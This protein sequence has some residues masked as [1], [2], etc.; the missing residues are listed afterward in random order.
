MK[1]VSKQ[2]PEFNRFAKELFSRIYGMNTIKAQDTP[3]WYQW[4][5]DLH[6]CIDE[7][8]EIKT[9]HNKAA[10]DPIKAALSTVE[11]LKSIVPKLPEAK[12]DN[13]EE[14]DK[15]LEALEGLAEEMETHAGQSVDP[16]KIERAHDRLEA[17][18]EAAQEKG[19][20]VQIPH[21]EMRAAI[22]GTIE[23]L[24]EN[25]EKF[26]MLVEM[27]GTL[28]ERLK[29]DSTKEYLQA[30]KRAQYDKELMK[31][32]DLCGNLENS[33]AREKQN[34]ETYSRQESSDIVLGDDIS[35]ALLVE[36][37]DDDLFDLKFINGELLM[38][39]VKTKEPKEK[40]DVVVCVDFSGSMSCEN[41]DTIA[42]AIV[43][44]LYSQMRKEHRKFAA[45]LFNG[46]VIYE[47][48]HERGSVLEFV[49]FKPSGGT[50]IEPAFEWAAEKI[51]PDADVVIIT[52]GGFYVSNP[53]DWRARFSKCNI[54]SVLI[55]GSVESLAALSDKVIET[56]DLMFS[57]NE[58]FRF[59]Q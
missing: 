31:F 27:P 1:E 35:R 40:G 21:E 43:V 16:K 26:E 58:I 14:I 53:E 12:L 33:Y 44:A 25:M 51:T 3:Y 52:D 37:M 38:R 28:E 32:F 59:V 47:F 56:N 57:S 45:C 13:L 17:R 49:E 2:Y 15:A 7:V 19:G 22:R 42:K 6:E 36:H 30:F 24:N 8:G 55:G 10:R 18:K 20:E 11:I 4:A 48:S 50:R 5:A 23:D 29:H 34:I 46:G 9:L 39:D 41:R 54:M